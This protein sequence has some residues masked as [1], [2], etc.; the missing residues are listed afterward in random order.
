MCCGMP[1][2]TIRALRQKPNVIKPFHGVSAGGT[3]TGCSRSFS[4]QTLTA[5]K[6]N[7]SMIAT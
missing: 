2:Y 6:L 7:I 5:Q 1:V 4:R 3:F